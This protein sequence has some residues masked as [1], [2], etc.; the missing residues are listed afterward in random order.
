[1]KKSE[2]KLIIKEVLNNEEENIT[3]IGKK[4]LDKKFKKL[5]LDNIDDLDWM[6]ESDNYTY[7]D[8]KV[9]SWLG[10]G[11]RPP[12]DKILKKIVIPQI[13]IN[14]EYLWKIILQQHLEEYVDKNLMDLTKNQTIF[15]QLSNEIKKYI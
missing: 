1:M 6:F 8:K 11:N 5:L 15:K 13:N 10:D 12:M 7:I 9:A 2:L 3:P 4:I 14:Y